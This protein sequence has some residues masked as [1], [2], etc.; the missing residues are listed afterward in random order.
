[1]PQIMSLEGPQLGPANVMRMG[2]DGVHVA[3]LEG[4]WQD[5]TDTMADAASRVGSIFSAKAPAQ[6]VI[7]RPL[8]GALD[9][10]TTRPWIVIVGIGLGMW[11]AGSERG[12]KLTKS[13]GFSGPK[14]KRRR[15]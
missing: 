4:F 2:R 9:P 12:K 6:R 11:L 8:R 3:P 14:R 13:Y 5:V 7:K 10:I 15:R 1:M